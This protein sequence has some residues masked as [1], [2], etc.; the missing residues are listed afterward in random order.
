M[1]INKVIVYPQSRALQV[2]RDVD[3][4]GV[5]FPMFGWYEPEV[6]VQIARVVMLDEF[7]I[8]IIRTL[9]RRNLCA[10]MNTS[11]QGKGLIHGSSDAIG[12]ISDESFHRFGFA[13]TRKTF[14]AIFPPSGESG[15]QNGKVCRYNAPTME[16][17]CQISEFPRF[18]EC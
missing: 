9:M 2:S 10:G 15:W 8:I 14:N 18:R 3:E 6:E 4:I 7:T 1:V 13:A 16:R 11:V 17:F 12:Q 5:F